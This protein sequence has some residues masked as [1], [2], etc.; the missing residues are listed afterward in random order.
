MDGATLLNSNAYRIFLTEI[1]KHLSRTSDLLTGP[2]DLASDAP[3]RAAASFHT[4]KG[5]AGFFGLTEVAQIAA[6]LEDLLNSDRLTET[7]LS[8]AQTLIVTLKRLSLELPRPKE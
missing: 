3:R 4:V 1:D 8:E 2:I 6:R 7:D 5:G